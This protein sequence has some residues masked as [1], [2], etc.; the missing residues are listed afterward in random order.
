MS[1][2]PKTSIKKLKKLSKVLLKFHI[3]P[4]IDN[5]IQPLNWPKMKLTPKEAHFAE[6]EIIE[7]QKA[8]GRIIAENITPY[9]PCIPILI[10][11]EVIEEQHLKFFGKT[12]KVLK[13]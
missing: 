11:G 13:K 7:S 9:P 2:N 12:V 1:K 3:K 8:K 6:Y 10:A 5:K 4:S